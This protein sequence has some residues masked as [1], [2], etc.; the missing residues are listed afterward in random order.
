MIIK[1]FANRQ[2]LVE[3]CQISI[4]KNIHLTSTDNSY[5]CYLDQHNLTCTFVYYLKI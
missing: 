5:L 3:D 2:L 1:P 4:F